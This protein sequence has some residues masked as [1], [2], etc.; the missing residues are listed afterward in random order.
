MNG[1]RPFNYWFRR[2]RGH[3]RNPILHYQIG[4][5]RFEL[6]IVSVDAADAGAEENYR[7]G[8]NGE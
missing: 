8:G 4:R 2:F 5:L 6:R 3:R 1:W 7:V